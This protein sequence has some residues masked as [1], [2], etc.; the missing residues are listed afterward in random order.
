MGDDLFRH[1]MII[2]IEK[3]FADKISSDKIIGIFDLIGKRK[4]HFKL[5]KT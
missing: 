1:C 2:Y 5:I 3:E 4:Y